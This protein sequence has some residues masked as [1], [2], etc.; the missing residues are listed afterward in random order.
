MGS[1]GTGG[2]E[3]TNRDTGFDG[4]G[5]PQFRFHGVSFSSSASSS[6]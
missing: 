6:N 2:L 5:S 3:P 4:T 1:G